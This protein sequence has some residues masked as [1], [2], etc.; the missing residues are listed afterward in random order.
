MSTR[1]LPCLLLAL[2]AL[3]LL[4]PTAASAASGTV[5]LSSDAY[6]VQE[7]AGAAEITVTR[8]DARGRGEV[9]Y[10]VWYDQSAQPYREYEPVEGVVEFQDGQDTATFQIPIHDDGDVEDAETVKLGIYGPYPMQLAEPNRA[11][12]TILDDD[13][14]SGVRDPINPLGLNPAPTNGN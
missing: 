12:L 1:R 7:N 10:G 2:A 3:P 4:G 13:T 9:R 14:V 6:N 11:R 8:S 5:R